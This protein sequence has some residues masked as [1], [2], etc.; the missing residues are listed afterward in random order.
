MI[1]N[2]SHGKATNRHVE[3]EERA[4]AYEV[5]CKKIGAVRSR[6]T[7]NW[8]QREVDKLQPSLRNMKKEQ[9]A[10]EKHSD[11]EKENFRLLQ[12]Y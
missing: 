4:R 12:R 1:K 5:H 3:A 10:I 9:K 2:L 11:I 6:I 8:S 7:S